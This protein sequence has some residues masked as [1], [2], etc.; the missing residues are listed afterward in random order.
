ME[1]DD[2]G[3]KIALLETE[4]ER[5]SS[6]VD[7]R[8]KTEIHDIHRAMEEQREEMERDMDVQRAN[9]ARKIQEIKEVVVEA[10]MAIEDD[11]RRV[12]E[13]VDE[14]RDEQEALKDRLAAVERRSRANA[15]RAQKVLGRVRLF[16]Y[17][18]PRYR[19]LRRSLRAMLRAMMGRIRQR[20]RRGGTGRAE[21]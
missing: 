3:R 1:L 5:R 6:R 9:I 15:L 21:V 2:I 7:E 16:L 18:Y 8:H 12:I 13:M 17:A 10:R 4:L 19:R 14:V 11:N 20:R